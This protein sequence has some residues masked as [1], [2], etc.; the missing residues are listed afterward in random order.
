MCVL[1]HNLSAQLGALYVCTKIQCERST[2]GFVCVYYTGVCVC[3]LY[4]VLFVCTTVDTT[5]IP[6]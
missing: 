1:R 4:G 5:C 2:R 3:V 6:N